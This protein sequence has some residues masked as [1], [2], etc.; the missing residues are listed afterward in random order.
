MSVVHIIIGGNVE[1]QLKINS[2]LNKFKAVKI[3]DFEYQFPQDLTTDIAKIVEIFWEFEKINKCKFL[4]FIDG[5]DLHTARPHSF[6]IR[7]EQLLGNTSP[8]NFQLVKE[9][10]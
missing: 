6:A 2:A 10:L 3:A 8:K 1:V 7:V 5:T 4:L 9:I